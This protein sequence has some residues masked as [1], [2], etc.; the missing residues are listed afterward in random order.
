MFSLTVYFNADAIPLFQQ[1]SV[2]YTLSLFLSL[3]CLALF[4]APIVWYKNPGIHFHL[5]IDLNSLIWTTSLFHLEVA[6]NS[7][8]KFSKLWQRRYLLKLHVLH[9][10]TNSDSAYTQCVIETFLV[11]MATTFQ[12]HHSRVGSR[13]YLQTLDKAVNACQGQ[14][15]KLIWSICKL[16][17]LKFY[18]L[19]PRS[20]IVITTQPVSTPGT[21]C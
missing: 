21:H 20:G 8:W 12:V 14:T 19:M 7:C 11:K 2:S 13:P 15:L 6:H 17:P 9:V 4:P 10:I 5:I 16:W 18:N 3:R 1:C